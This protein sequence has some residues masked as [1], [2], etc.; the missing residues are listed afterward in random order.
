MTRF[1][2]RSLALG[3][4]LF[5]FSGVAKA[6]GPL[7]A[8]ASSLA[9]P[10]SFRSDSD[11]TYL[12]AFLK[13]NSAGNSGG[14]G[15]EIGYKGMSLGFNQ[16]ETRNYLQRTE[17]K[18]SVSEAA[19]ILTTRVSGEQLKAWELC[20]S[21]LS[22]GNIFYMKSVSTTGAIL[23]GTIVWRSGSGVA[24]VQNATVQVVGDAMKPNT[25]AIVKKQI[26][27]ALKGKLA[28]DAAPFGEKL[29]DPTKPLAINV[30][31]SVGSA[32]IGANLYVPPA[33]PYNPP[34]AAEVVSAVLDVDRLSMIDALMRG[35]APNQATDTEL[36]TALHRL[37]EVCMKTPGHD[38]KKLEEFA[39]ILLLSGAD[40]TLKNK[41]NETAYN[42]ASSSKYCGAG[43]PLTKLLFY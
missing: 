29:D 8:C 10:E 23:T 9:Q 28:V 14:T 43:H 32:S 25:A 30:N 39:R 2:R 5:G 13:A 38:K 35:W 3:I 27:D 1:I 40:R 24:A 17:S 22:S 26:E 21:T 31:V 15:L 34:T 4:V 33:I 20:I 18:L 41:W 19:S 7:D 37:P 6:Q 16:N 36:N 11:R 12:Q 42:I